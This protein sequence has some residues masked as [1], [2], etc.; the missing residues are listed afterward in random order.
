MK[1]LNRAAVAAAMLCALALAACA[2]GPNPLDAQTRNSFYVKD[3]SIDWALNDAKK[4][5]DADYVQGKKDMAEHLERTV[6]REF[7]TSPSGSDAAHFRIKVTAY[8]RAGT[9]AGNI[10]GLSNAMQADVD[11]VRDSDGKVLGT[12]KNVHGLY[13]AGGGVLGAMVQSV[14]KPDVAQLLAADFTKDLRKKFNAS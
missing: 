13:T 14:T 3:A 1:S 2:T 10:I 4:D 11:V 6:E 12:Y 8:S 9:L 7:K 5:S